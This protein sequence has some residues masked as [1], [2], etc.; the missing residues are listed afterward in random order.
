M[1]PSRSSRDISTLISSQE[2]TL[3][4][5]RSRRAFDTGGRPYSRSVNLLTQDTENSVAANK[6]DGAVFVDL[7]AAYD[8]VWHHSLTYKLLLLLPDRHMGCMIMGIV[9][10]H[11]F[12]LATGNCK[13]NRFRRLKNGAPQGSVLAPLLF[14]IY[15]SDLPTTVSCTYAYADDLATMHADG[16]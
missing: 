4:S 14:N 6:V 15:I 13:P 8:A 2:S 9:G 7:T 11:S 10:N 16:D 12:T 3:C 1:S 5:N